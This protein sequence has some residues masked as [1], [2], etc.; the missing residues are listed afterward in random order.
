[1]I[2]TKAPLYPAGDT[3]EVIF[4]NKFVTITVADCY[5]I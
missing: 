2:Y 1:M 5:I 3:L 4:F